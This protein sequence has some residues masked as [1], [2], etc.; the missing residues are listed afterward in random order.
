MPNELVFPDAETARDVLTFAERAVKAGTEGV[1]VTAH[2]GVAVVTVAVLASQGLLDPTPLVLG[3]RIAQ[4]DPEL[5]CDLVVRELH[6]GSASNTLTLPETALAPAWAGVSPPRGGWVRTRQLPA[7]LIAN[8]AQWGISAVA[9]GSPTG[10]GEHAVQSLRTAVWGAPDDELDGL[11]RGVAFA[12]HALGFI[13]GEELAAVSESGR[14]KRVSLVR[15][16]I[17]TRGPALTGMTP[18][19]TTG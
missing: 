4:I 13:Q 1:R 18:V 8:R 10:S 19:R 17:L 3:V 15:G 12:A 2:R 11:P 6:R 5:E 16:H 14:W 9:H 7:A